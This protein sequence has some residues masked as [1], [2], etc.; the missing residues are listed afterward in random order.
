MSV[1]K[2]AAQNANSQGEQQTAR[3]RDDRLDD[4]YLIEMTAFL[5]SEIRARDWK[6]IFKC[7]EGV[8]ILLLSDIWLKRLKCCQ[9][10]NEFPWGDTEIW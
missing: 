8:G 2:V 5:Q 10:P 7:M 6:G 9:F 4:V 1:S 3:A